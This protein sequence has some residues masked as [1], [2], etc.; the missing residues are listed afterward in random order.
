MP[1]HRAS[2]SA[3]ITLDRDDDDVDERVRSSSPSSP[4]SSCSSL[5]LVLFVSAAIFFMTLFGIRRVS[6]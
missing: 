6:F 3:D 2:L 4:S 5:F 1:C